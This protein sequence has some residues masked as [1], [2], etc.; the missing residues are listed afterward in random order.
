MDYAPINMRAFSLTFWVFWAF[1]NDKRKIEKQQKNQICNRNADLPC[2]WARMYWKILFRLCS[3]KFSTCCTKNIHRILKCFDRLRSNFYK[4]ASLRL[5]RFTFWNPGFMTLNLQIIF[6]DC[7]RSN[8]TLSTCIIISLT[9]PCTLL[10][11]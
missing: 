8:L 7:W 3:S 6:Q 4:L 2:W 10:L 5:T 9:L 1:W 11:T